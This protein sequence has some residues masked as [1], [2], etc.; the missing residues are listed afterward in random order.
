MP[1][2]DRVFGTFY[3]PKDQWPSAYGIEGRMAESLGGQLLQ[4]LRQ[5]RPSNVA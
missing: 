5:Q 2:L 1:W 4:P 3:V